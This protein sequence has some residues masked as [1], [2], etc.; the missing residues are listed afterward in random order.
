MVTEFRLLNSTSDRTGEIVLRANANK[1]VERLVYD[2]LNTLVDPTYIQDFLLTY[3]VFIDNPTFVSNKLIEWFENAHAYSSSSSVSFVSLNNSTSSLSPTNVSNNL[4]KK[5]Y[6]IVLEWIT[7]HFNDFEINKDLYD[8][9]ERFQVNRVKVLS[10][11]ANFE[12]FSWVQSTIFLKILS[13]FLTN[14]VM[15]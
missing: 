9:V 15:L 10:F 2:D 1:L 8:F 14:R 12:Y 5:V 11:L 13:G 4:K 3:R 7:N 6:R